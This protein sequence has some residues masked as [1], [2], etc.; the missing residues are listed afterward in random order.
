MNEI[1][2][3]AGELY[4]DRNKSVYKFLYDGSDDKYIPNCEKLI[5]CVIS[6]SGGIG[7]C[8]RYKNGRCFEPEENRRDIIKRCESKNSK[9][10]EIKLLLTHLGEFY[11]DKYNEKV[12]LSSR[13]FDYHINSIQEKILLLIED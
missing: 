9:I 8:W 4:E 1:E 12:H 5:F 6:N 7:I 2:W 13:F 10:G 11:N 3:I